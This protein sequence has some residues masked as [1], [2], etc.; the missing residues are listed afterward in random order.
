MTRYMHESC[1]VMWIFPK[2][3]VEDNKLTTGSMYRKV[4]MEFELYFTLATRLFF[5]GLV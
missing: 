4:D 2:L 5:M 3:V 1:H